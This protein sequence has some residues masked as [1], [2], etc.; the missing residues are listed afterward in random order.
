MTGR[1]LL[2]LG[3][4]GGAGTTTLQ[5]LV[6]VGVE[7]GQWPAFDREPLV[8]VVARTNARGLMAA[9]QIAIDRSSTGQL[10]GLVLVA[11]ARGKLP[12]PLENLARLV[13]GGYTDSYRVPWVEAW[14]LG[15]PPVLRLAPPVVR[16]L[17]VELCFAAS[18]GQSNIKTNERLEHAPLLVTA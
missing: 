13:A 18:H 12:K 1:R 17:A 10:A 7:T 15:A 11:D 14:R 6:G 16:R 9:Q 2:W 8:V 5:G 4:H 3:A